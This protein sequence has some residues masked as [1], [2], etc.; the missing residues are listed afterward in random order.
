MILQEVSIIQIQAYK[1]FGT[2]T[3]PIFLKITIMVL[4]TQDQMYINLTSAEGRVSL[5]L[6]G[7][8]IYISNNKF[9]FK[10]RNYTGQADFPD[11]RYLLRMVLFIHL[12]R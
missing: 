9:Q 6:I 5:Y 11:L 4:L 3:S 2:T 1:T 8:E 12:I 10:Y 7:T